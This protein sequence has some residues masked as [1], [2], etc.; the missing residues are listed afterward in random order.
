MI[1]RKGLQGLSRFDQPA[2]HGMRGDFEAPGPGADTQACGQSGDGLYQLIWI[3]L[4]AVPGRAHCFQA[5]TAT[6]E[7]K[8]WSPAASIG[9][10]MGADIAPA[11]RP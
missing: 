2:Q 3:N 4:F 6:A 5:R 8:A 9:M 10:T 11:P 7:T 1:A